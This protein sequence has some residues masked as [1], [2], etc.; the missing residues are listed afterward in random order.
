MLLDEAIEGAL[1]DGRA[2]GEVAAPADAALAAG[3]RVG[4][5]PRRQRDLVVEVVEG[6]DDD[7]VRVALVPLPQRLEIRD[8]LLVALLRGPSI[9]LIALRTAASLSSCEPSGWVV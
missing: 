8:V 1:V 3:R 9:S 4:R 5:R 6:R 2:L 7:A